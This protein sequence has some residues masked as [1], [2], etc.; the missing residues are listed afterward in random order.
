M[1]R[2]K[3]N[4]NVSILNSHRVR[5]CVSVPLTTFPPSEKKKKTLQNH[6][7]RQITAETQ[8]TGVK[9]RQGCRIWSIPEGAYQL[10]ERRER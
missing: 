7:G 8:L 6:G 10:G 9:E 2:L 1:R 5:G 4:Q 3:P